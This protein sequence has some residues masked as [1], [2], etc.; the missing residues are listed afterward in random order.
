MIVRKLEIPRC[1]AATYGTSICND[2]A[3]YVV[4]DSNGET[5]NCCNGH[6]SN[7]IERFEKAAEVIEG[8]VES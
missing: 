6:I 5:L 1:V 8:R 4:E 7:L 2:P 3:T